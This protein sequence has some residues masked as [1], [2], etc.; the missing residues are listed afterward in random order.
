MSLNGCEK[1]LEVWVDKCVIGHNLCP[2]A[3]PVR[4]STRIAV[5]KTDSLDGLL[6][7]CS[8]EI[9]LLGNAKCAGVGAA[10]ADTDAADGVETTLLG[11]EV[12][13]DIKGGHGEGGGGF[14]SSFSQMLEAAV[15][16]EALLH[17]H[18]SQ[19]HVPSN[20]LQ[21]AIFHPM[22]VARL[23][24]HSKSLASMMAKHEEGQR[25]GDCSGIG[26]HAGDLVLRSP[27][28]V[29]HFLRKSAVL[30]AV[31]SYSSAGSGAESI[32]D[33]NNARM[34]ALAR[35][36]QLGAFREALGT[37]MPITVRHDHDHEPSS[38]L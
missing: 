2:F 16:V 20:T 19:T 13:K 11:I 6:Q 34:C 27:L 33:K 5:K 32:P 25:S 9:A 8:S 4:S 37:Q 15:A 24:E 18:N 1:Q 35:R 38:L 31:K 3:A 10:A 23:M 22:A 12:E 36:E 7:L 17:E 28:P 30:T 14:L 26:A 29:F 21:L